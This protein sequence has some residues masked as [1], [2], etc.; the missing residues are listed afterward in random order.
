M[1]ENLDHR[2]CSRHRKVLVDQTIGYQFSDCFLRVH[3]H[4]ATECLTDGFIL[5]KLRVDEGH[6]RLE[7]K[8]IALLRGS[9]SPFSLRI[10]A[11]IPEYGIR[12]RSRARSAK[13]SLASLFAAS[14]SPSSYPYGMALPHDLF[15]DCRVNCL[16]AA[17]L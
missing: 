5:W 8:G 9:V 12:P 7:R 14:Q 6:R 2:T 3:S 13:M 4:F 10:G 16:K 1:R 11:T 15:F 17:Q